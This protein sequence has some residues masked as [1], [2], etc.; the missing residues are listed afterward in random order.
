MITADHVHLLQTRD[1][2]LA[3]PAG[4]LRNWPLAGFLRPLPSI[5]V[6]L[7]R[8]QFGGVLRRV[9]LPPICRCVGERGTEEILFPKIYACQ[10]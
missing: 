6:T 7:P 9:R 8:M 5:W 3:P 4:K 1:R 10:S 2:R